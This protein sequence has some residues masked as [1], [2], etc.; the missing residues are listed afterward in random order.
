MHTLL[1]W[2]PIFTQNQS[3]NQN[4]LEISNMI[5]LSED[6][7]YEYKEDTEKFPLSFRITNPETQISTIA[8]VKDFTSLPGTCIIPNHIL[9]SLMLTDG[10]TV[11]VK[12]EAVP[13]GDYI[14]LKF[15]ETKLAKLP[16]IKELLQKSLEKN[17]PILTKNETIIIENIETDE[18]G[19]M[20]PKKYLIDV[21]DTK[22]VESIRI[23]NKVINVDFDKPY[24]YVEEK[25]GDDGAG[26]GAG[27]CE[28]DCE[29]DCAGNGA[30]DGAGG[31]F[32]GAGYRLDGVKVENVVYTKNVRNDVRN[33]VR[34][35]EIVDSFKSKVC[36]SFVP[37]SGKGYKLGDK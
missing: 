17:Y 12:Y 15:H 32:S 27:D 3:H 23:T 33:D 21:V 34:K 13:D 37:F 30:G 18:N 19:D 9:Q 7:L 6:I 4:E 36:K 14:K 10:S 31:V 26:D 24:D 16:N 22:P 11:E 20:F 25:I 8:Q 5:I 29:G 35:R 2:S 28:G 1:A